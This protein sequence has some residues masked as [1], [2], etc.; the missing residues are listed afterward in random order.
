MT[1]ETESE[2]NVLILL[3]CQNHALISF[4]AFVF[5]L[6]LRLWLI[7]LLPFSVLFLRASPNV[8]TRPIERIVPRPR[9]AVRRLHARLRQKE[10]LLRQLQK[11]AL[12]RRS[13]HSPRR[14]ALRI[15]A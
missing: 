2:S 10:Q 14:T 9:F 4:S 6:C 1:D 12:S 3:S 15:R 5:A 7:T 8:R 13:D 11:G